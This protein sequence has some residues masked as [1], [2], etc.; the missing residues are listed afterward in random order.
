MSTK[1]KLQKSKSFDLSSPSELD[2]IK[3]KQQHE[4]STFDRR[5]M[6]DVSSELFP[7]EI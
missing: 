1:S 3:R 5:A 2:G 7:L 6:E 4:V